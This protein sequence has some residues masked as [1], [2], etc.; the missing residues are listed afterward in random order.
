MEI[1]WSKLM[2]VLTLSTVPY[3]NWNVMIY[4]DERGSFNL[5]TVPYWNWNKF[6]NSHHILS[7]ISFNRTILELKYVRKIRDQIT[8][9]DFQPYHTG[10]EMCAFACYPGTKLTFNRT[11][12]ELK[13]GTAG[14][15]I[16]S[17][18]LSTVPYW[19]WNSLIMNT[20]NLTDSFQPYHTGIEIW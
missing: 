17:V 5:S 3:W 2:K 18:F 15:V 8:I 19:N 1:T 13:F 20:E 9:E 14:S 12:L 4:L 11:I 10:I 16:D 6:T 7:C